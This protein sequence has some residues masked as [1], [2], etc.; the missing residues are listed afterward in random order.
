MTEAARSAR[1][2]TWDTLPPGDAS[3][4]QSWATFL[5]SLPDCA[6]ACMADGIEQLQRALRG[7][8]VDT[9]DSG[10]TIAPRAFQQDLPL[11][12]SINSR[13]ARW[14]WL[15]VKPEL[16]RDILRNGWAD[17]KI[18]KDYPYAATSAT[19]P[20]PSASQ[21]AIEKQ[22]PKMLEMGVIAQVEDPPMIP[23]TS[24]QFHV[25][26]N[27]PKEK[28]DENGVV[29]EEVRVVTS[30]KT[31]ST[32]EEVPKF[33]GFSPDDYC[34]WTRPGRVSLKGDLSKMFWQVRAK[35]AQSNLMM[36]YWGDTLYQWKVMVMGMAGSG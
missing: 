13:S 17:P 16:H 22:Y 12:G 25:I 21:D 3:L 30:T 32:N 14:S 10:W 27:A 35:Q 36:F 2:S 34:R 23:L 11:T 7:Q 4:V 31:E 1:A 29:L 19:K 6:P 24:D 5:S 26:R 8:P 33:Q 18:D 9:S 15:G 20:P 28:K